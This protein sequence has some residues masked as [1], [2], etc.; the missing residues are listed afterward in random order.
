MCIFKQIQSLVH[1]NLTVYQILED[2]KGGIVIC[3]KAYFRKQ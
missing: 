2:F 3:L 1:Q